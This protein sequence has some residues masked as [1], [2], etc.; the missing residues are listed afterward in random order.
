MINDLYCEC[1]KLCFIYH[2]FYAISHAECGKLWQPGL[3][4][5][6]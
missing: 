1:F 2:P 5:V 3:D 6:M 4:I